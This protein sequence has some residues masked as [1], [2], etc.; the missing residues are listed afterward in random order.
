[1][2]IAHYIT[3]PPMGIQVLCD[4]SAFCTKLRQVKL[5]VAHSGI[6]RLIES[7][8]IADNPRDRPDLT[9]FVNLPNKAGNTAL[10]W[11]SLN[12]HL[13]TVQ[14]LVTLGADHAAMNVFKHSAAFEA[15]NDGQKEVADWLHGE[16]QG[17][18]QETGQ[19]AGTTK[20]IDD[21]EHSDTEHESTSVPADDISEA[22]S[23]MHVSDLNLRSNGV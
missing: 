3:L 4:G 14:L 22:V 6:I 15:E 5:T 10:H 23:E 16:G 1:M 12:G 17:T 7:S 9:T 11:A 8:F 2:A 13:S 19:P 18:E 21:G 20:Q